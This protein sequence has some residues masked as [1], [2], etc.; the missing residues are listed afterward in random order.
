[1]GLSQNERYCQ[2][3][4]RQI[5]DVVLSCFIMCYLLRKSKSKTRQK[6]IGFWELKLPSIRNQGNHDW[7]VVTGTIDFYDFLKWEDIYPNW[8]TPLSF[9][10]VDQPR[11]RWKWSRVCWCQFRNQSGFVGKCWEQYAKAHSIDCN[12]IQ[13]IVFGKKHNLQDPPDFT[14]FYKKSM[15]SG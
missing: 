2:Q 7:L 1:M 8:R 14:W 13:W 11:T 4:T 3:A 9:R 15:V 10:G 12:T 6:N 5:H